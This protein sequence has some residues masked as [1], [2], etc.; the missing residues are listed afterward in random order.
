MRLPGQTTL[1]TRVA[2]ISKQKIKADRLLSMYQI[3]CERLL[4]DPP[5]TPTATGREHFVFVL[6]GYSSQTILFTRVAKINKRKVKAA[7]LFPTHQVGCD[8]LSIDLSGTPTT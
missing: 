5:G 4:I 7:K 8:S 2:K 1:L 6:C 3:E